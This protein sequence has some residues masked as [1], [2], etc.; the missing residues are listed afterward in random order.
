M[1]QSMEAII[2]AVTTQVLAALEQENKLPDRRSE[3]KTRCLVLGDSDHIP[4]ALRR[5]AVLLGLEDYQ[6]HQTI[7]NYARVL[8]TRLDFAD[9]A[10]IA[11]GRGGTPAARAVCCA[12]L[13]GTEVLLLECALPHR[14][15]AGRGST[16]LYQLLERYV[17]TLL[18]FGVKLLGSGDA[19]PALRGGLLEPKAPVVRREVRDVR[20]IT[21]ALAQALAK[22]AQELDIPARTLITPAAMDIFQASHTTLIRR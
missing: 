14:A 3:G 1:D 5:D 6:T 2:Q 11:L 13:Q 16:A 21:E 9:L 20:L 15:F 10:D 12:L 17:N 4:Q 18:V 7:T 8:I 19:M 22:D